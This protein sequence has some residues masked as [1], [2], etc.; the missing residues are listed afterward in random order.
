MFSTLQPYLIIFQLSLTQLPTNELSTLSHQFFEK[1]EKNLMPL[2]KPVTNYLLLVQNEISISH[3]S[4]LLVLQKCVSAT[5]L[6][7]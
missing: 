5:F 3:A 6:K 1:E 7:M 2:Y 4:A